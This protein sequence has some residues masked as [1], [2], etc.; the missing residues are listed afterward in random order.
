MIINT[1][2]RCLS[3]NISIIA[4]ELKIKIRNAHL[5]EIVK[6]QKEDIKNISK[7]KKDYKILTNIIFTSQSAADIG[8][9]IL[10]SLNKNYLL[11][12]NIF[13]IGPATKKRVSL[14]GYNSIIPSKFN[15]EGLIEVLEKYKQYKS[16]IVCGESS[17]GLIKE[18]LNCPEMI[19]YKQNYLERNLRFVK[20]ENNIILIY[21]LEIC[22]FIF[23]NIDFNSKQEISFVVSSCRI[24]NYIRKNYPTVGKIIVAKNA[25]DEEMLISAMHV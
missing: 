14:L 21:N 5:S 16:L 2:P 8:I 24:R 17:R 6:I 15:S 18:Y 25:T 3:K 9:R 23:S 12:K 11:N 1:R 20:G 4:K 19:C 13:S 22:R 7:I 10:E